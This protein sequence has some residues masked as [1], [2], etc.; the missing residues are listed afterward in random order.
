MPQQD[1][2]K[3]IRNLIDDWAAGLRAKD[4]KR[5]KRHGAEDLVH[6]SLAPPLVADENGAYGLETWFDTWHGPLG[7]ELRDLE[8]VTGDGVA[9]SHSLNHLTGTQAAR[10]ATSGSAAR[11]VSARSVAN[12]R[13]RTSTSRCRSSWTAATRPHS[14]SIPEVE[15]AAL[16][17]TVTT[18]AWGVRGH[19]D[20]E[21]RMGRRL[22]PPGVLAPLSHPCT[23]GLKCALRKR[24]V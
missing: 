20:G 13:S 19:R 14:I 21:R 1:D 16:A 4:A 17:S 24:A 12:G 10:R 11:S 8:I 3:Q 22:R 6:F 18:V 2:V 7:Y 9:F 23:A 15:A 5:V